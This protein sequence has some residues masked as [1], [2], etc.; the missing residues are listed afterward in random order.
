MRSRGQP[1]GYVLLMVG[2]Y[3]TARLGL[4]GR[5]TDDV[6]RVLGRLPRPVRAYVEDYAGEFRSAA[7]GG[8]SRL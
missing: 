7:G 2:I 6:E 1:L 8:A 4:A 5:V 3:T